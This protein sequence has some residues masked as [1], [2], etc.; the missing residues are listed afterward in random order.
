MPTSAAKAGIGPTPNQH[1]LSTSDILLLAV[2][3]GLVAGFLELCGLVLSKQVL[4]TTEYYK[5]GKFFWWG[6][7][8]S[9]L[10]ILII[11]GTAAAGFSRFRLGPVPLRVS[12]WML[13]TLALWA[14]LLNM[15]IAGWAGLL[16]RR[17]SVV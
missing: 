14:L 15:P 1:V 6:V 7:P 3:F 8:L 4:H 5:Q 17:A 12:I 13:A 10:V 9:N 11:P 2:W 16:L